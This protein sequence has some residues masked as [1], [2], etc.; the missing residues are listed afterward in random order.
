M[1]QHRK[2]GF[3]ALV[4]RPNAG[5]SSFLNA[6]L[7]QKV[8]IVSNTPQTTQRPIRGIYTTDDVQMIFMDVPGFHESMR[9]WNQQLNDVVIRSLA[10]CDAI[11]RFIDST[12]EYGK[13]EILIDD[14]IAQSGKPIITVY[15]K[16]DMLENRDS[17]PKD[18]RVLSSQTQEG[19]PEVITGLTEFLPEGELL[20]SEDDI[21]DQ[22]VFTRISETIREKIFTLY[23]HEIPHSVY[24][25]IFSF[26]DTSGLVRIEAIIHCENDSQKKILI[27]KQ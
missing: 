19:F 14:I 20:Y 8:S 17:I 9:D 21:T 26:E 24:I 27:G 7:E 11:L 2:V 1:T 12:R 18:A 25:E 5:K 10:E 15:S 3:V 16:V 23:R 22:D 4:G 13:E 6:L